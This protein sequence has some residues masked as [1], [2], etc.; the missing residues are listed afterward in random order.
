MNGKAVRIGELMRQHEAK[1]GQRDAS[2]LDSLHRAVWIKLPLEVMRDCGRAVQ[3]LGGILAVS[4]R[5]T[6]LNQ[7]EISRHAGLP[8]GTLRRHLKTLD[9]REWIT[10]Q[11]RQRTSRGFLRRT[12]TL[13]VTEKTREA[14]RFYGVLPGWVSRDLKLP[15]CARAILSVWFARLMKLNAARKKT[16][17]YYDS[18]EVFIEETGA[19]K[20]HFPLSLL[21]RETGLARHSVIKAK[22]CLAETGIILLSTNGSESDSMLPNLDYR[23]PW[24]PY[25]NE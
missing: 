9:R 11:G 6:F 5:E 8:L 24:F 1:L 16:N 18:L 10:N 2:L 21:E 17:Y 22:R 12:A 19:D 4:T 7:T 15:W 14:R 20:F 3:T 13:T 23:I 25:S